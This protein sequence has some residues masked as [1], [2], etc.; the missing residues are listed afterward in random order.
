MKKTCLS[1]L[2]IVVAILGAGCKDSTAPTPTPRRQLLECL[3]DN[4][5]VVRCHLTLDQAGGFEIV[6]SH[7]ACQ[8]RE[9]SIRLV[10]PVDAVITADGC[11]ASDMDKQ[12]LGPFPA[13]STIEIEFR[14]GYTGTGG[15]IRAQG[16]YPEWTFSFEDGYDDDY[17]DLRFVLRALPSP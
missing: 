13:G 3:D 10:S 16:S 9:N 8:A 15:F 5:A 6:D 17:D 7:S 14:S 1:C 11:Y 2:A 12:F 4:G